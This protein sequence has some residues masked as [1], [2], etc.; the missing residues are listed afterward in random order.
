MYTDQV[1]SYIK[2]AKSKS[3]QTPISNHFPIGLYLVSYQ[4]IFPRG[5]KTE[6]RDENGKLV[7]NMKTMSSIT[8]GKIF[9]KDEID[10]VVKSLTEQGYKRVKKKEM[11]IDLPRACPRCHNIGSPKIAKMKK[12]YTP[13]HDKLSDEEKSKL[14]YT[15]LHYGHSTT[16]PETCLIGDILASSKGIEIKLMNKLEVGCLGYRNRVG[17]YPMPKTND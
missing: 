14:Y 9:S 7:Y 8:P 15:K 1:G 3:H 16:K 13:R 5:A 4:P 2:L 12:R 6:I 17:E 10:N 11:T